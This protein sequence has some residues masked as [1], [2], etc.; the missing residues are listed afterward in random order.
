[1]AEDFTLLKDSVD[2]PVCAFQIGSNAL[3][4][5]L[6][7]AV[8]VIDEVQTTDA[9]GFFQCA[10][11]PLLD[12]DGDGALT[13]ADILPRN[14]G[15]GVALFVGTAAAD[16]DSNTGK[17]KL[18][19]DSGLTTPVAST[20]C[21]CTYYYAVPVSFDSSGRLILAPTNSVEVSASVLPTGAATEAKQDTLIAKDFATQITLAAVLAKII[22]APATEAKQD[23]LIAKDFATQT[24]LAAI[25]TTLF[26]V[27]DAIADNTQGALLASAAR[28]ATQTT[29]DQTNYN[30]RGIH[31]ILDVTSITDTPSIV[32]KIEGK[33][34]SGVYYTLLESVAV[35]G[36][37]THVYKVMPWATPVVNEAAADLL[38]RTWRVVVTHAD[39]DSITYSVDY[40]IDC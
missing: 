4:Q 38:P 27:L 16:L 8:K 26:A 35:I 2:I 28:T 25:Q 37:G 29:A 21:K 32:L 10:H 20:A 34:A 22:A 14:N 33:S 13:A 23:T 3:N 12:I 18:Y 1:M 6:F 11:A 9:S 17:F 24:T 39:T 40:A 30:G 7:A 15:T 36:T 31:V 5:V 19:S